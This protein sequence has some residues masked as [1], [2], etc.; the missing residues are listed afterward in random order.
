M[1]HQREKIREYM[2][3][4]HFVEYTFSD[5]IRCVSIRFVSIRCVSIRFVKYTFREYTFCEYTF[6]KCI[7]INIPIFYVM[8]CF[9]PIPLGGEFQWAVQQETAMHNL[10]NFQ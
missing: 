2:F 10:I 4:I 6:C 7:K 3:S 5:S 8:K 9:Q 1:E